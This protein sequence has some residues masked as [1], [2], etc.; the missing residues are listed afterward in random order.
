MLN[1]ASYPI[2]FLICYC[3][4]DLNQADT[5]VQPK[6]NLQRPGQAP[7]EQKKCDC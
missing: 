2:R 6:Q 3:S 7:P 1:C 5:G 4:L